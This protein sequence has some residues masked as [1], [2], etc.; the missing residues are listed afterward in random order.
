MEVGRGE[1]G[2]GGDPLGV[3]VGG[4]GGVVPGDPAESVLRVEQGEQGLGAGGEGVGAGV[5]VRPQV[6]EVPGVVLVSGDDQRGCGHGGEVDGPDDRPLLRRGPVE[7][8]AAPAGRGEQ[9]ARR[10]AGLGEVHHLPGVGVGDPGTQQEGGGEAAERVA[11]EGDPGVVDPSAEV[12]YGV[13]DHVEPVEDVGHVLGAGAPEVGR[14]GGVGD[15]V[16]QGAGGEVGGLDHDESV[17]R[18]VVGERCVA[19]ERGEVVRRAVAVREEDD[20]EAG[21]GGGCADAYLQVHGTSGHGQDHGTEGQD[22]DGHGR[23]VGGG[24]SAHGGV[25][26]RGGAC[27]SPAVGRWAGR[28]SGAS[29]FG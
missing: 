8:V 9:Y 23:G 4:L 27:P 13:L 16:G 21:S 10:D 1:P 25:P 3:L 2:D 18:P 26:F 6:G 15:Q 7:D 29:R 11:R 20:G 14:A 28:R 22:R 19:V 17:C 5:P 12:R 24:G